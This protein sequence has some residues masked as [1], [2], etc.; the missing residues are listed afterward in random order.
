MEAFETLVAALLERKGYWTRV[1]VKVELTKEEKRKIGRPSAP[2]WELDVIAYKAATN[3]LY[4]V[5]CKS[6]LDS[7]GVKLSSFDGS[8]EKGAAR[9]KLFNDLTLRRVVFNR[10]SLQLVE[11]GFC[12]SKPK[13]T[14]CLAAGNTYQDA[15]L[16]RQHFERN[17]WVLWD[18]DWVRRELAELSKSGYDNT[19]AAIVSKL[20][21]RPPKT[22]IK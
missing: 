17:D 22:T 5:E 14:L 8:N 4:V 1:S 16:L 21:L 6:Y 7:T 15:S 20:L 2:R 3:E 9:Y 11:A 13:I 12:P 18:G 10:L 19:V